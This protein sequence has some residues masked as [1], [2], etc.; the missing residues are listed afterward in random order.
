MCLGMNASA[1][2]ASTAAKEQK[3]AK[4]SVMVN[5]STASANTGRDDRSR[6]SRREE[7]VGLI[8]KGLRSGD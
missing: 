3:P 4:P 5:I 2:S 1:Q 7:L 8:P 6:A